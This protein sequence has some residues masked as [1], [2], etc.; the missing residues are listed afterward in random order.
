MAQRVGEADLCGTPGIHALGIDVMSMSHNLYVRHEIARWSLW[1]YGSGP[2]PN[3]DNDVRQ[4]LLVCGVLE[5]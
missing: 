3:G 2:I 1:A 4:E 5:Q